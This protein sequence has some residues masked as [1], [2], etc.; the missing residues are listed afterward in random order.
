MDLRTQCKTCFP[1]FALI[2]TVGTSAVPDSQAQVALLEKMLVES[3]ISIYLKMF[4]L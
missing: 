2:L 1:A 3:R 4:A